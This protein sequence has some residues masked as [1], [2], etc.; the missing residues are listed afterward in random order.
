MNK[1]MLYQNITALILLIFIGACNSQPVSPH[2]Q[3]AH[4]KEVL[5]KE[6]IHQIDS[7]SVIFKEKGA[8]DPYTVSKLIS[9]YTEYRNH[10]RE[11]E[12][13]PSY[14]LRA[15]E[16]AMMSK[17]W[18]KAAEI[19]R[20]FFNDYD[21]HPDR[22]DVLFQL[23]FIY[24]FELMDKSKAQQSY[25]H[26]YKLYQ[27]SVLIDQVSARLMDLNLSEEE[28]IEKFKKQNNIN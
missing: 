21:H 5:K 16:L 9:A 28:L 19:Y 3:K 12:R 17:K 24:D 11:D 2:E 6:L 13:A 22:D 4:D 26:Y 1:K 8:K 20:N 7:M 10:F 15:G 25:E 23:A 18:D 27:D 14:F